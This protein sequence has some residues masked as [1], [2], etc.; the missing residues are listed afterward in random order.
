M[1]YRDDE[2]RASQLDVIS[3][4]LDRFDAQVLANCLMGNRFHMVLH[5]PAQ[6]VA[7]AYALGTFTKSC[8]LQANPCRLDSATSRSISRSLTPRSAR[9]FAVSSR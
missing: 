4:A 2:D 6:T 1:I 3:H 8:G 7:R 5:T 9:L